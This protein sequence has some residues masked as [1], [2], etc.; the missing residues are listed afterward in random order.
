MT[1]PTIAITIGDF[2]GIGPE[3][4]VK[5]LN[6]KEILAF[7]KPILI[8]DT[9]VLDLLRK[10]GLLKKKFFT[11]NVEKNIP[12]GSGLGGGSANAADFLKF[13]NNKMHLRLNRNNKYT[14]H[15]Y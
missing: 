10:K 15:N 12:H 14:D 9:K 8:A 6:K 4:T 11:I 13:L 2:N 3:V 1:K 7:C 5:S